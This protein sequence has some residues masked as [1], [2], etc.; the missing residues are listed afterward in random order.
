MSKS[1]E[2]NT[3]RAYVCPKCGNR[4]TRELEAPEDDMGDITWLWECH[5]C[6]IAYTVHYEVEKAVYNAEDD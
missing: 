4:N 6:G 5:D 2:V 1:I 3:L